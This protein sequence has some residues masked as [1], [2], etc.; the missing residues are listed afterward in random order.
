[1]LALNYAL[2]LGYYTSLL[3]CIYLMGWITAQYIPPR[4]DAAFLNIKQDAL[5]YPY[6]GYA[7]YAHVWASLPVL[8]LGVPQ[9]SSRFR[10]HFVGLHQQLGKAYIGLILIVAAP[11]GLIMGLHA[12]GGWTAQCSFV[13]Q[14]LL[15]WGW[16]WYAYQKARQQDWEAHR[17]YMLLSYALTLSAISLRIWKWSIVALWAPP[18]MDTYRVVAWLGWGGNVLV[19]VLYQYVRQYRNHRTILDQ[20]K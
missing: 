17:Y 15:W 16:T 10:A 8:I 1:M 11:S 14:A 5:A 6:Y 13:L 12:N 3:Y 9:F 19:V 7:F 4:W 2:K 18:P 20:K